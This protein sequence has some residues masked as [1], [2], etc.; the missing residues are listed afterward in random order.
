MADLPWDSLL[1]PV[2]VVAPWWGTWIDRVGTVVPSG[3]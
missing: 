2:L 1:V 3:R